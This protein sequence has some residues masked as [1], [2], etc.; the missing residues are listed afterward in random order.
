MLQVV[1]GRPL[2][3]LPKWYITLMEKIKVTMESMATM[4]HYGI[5][6]AVL[7]SPIEGPG[8]A[9]DCCCN[10]CFNML[11]RLRVG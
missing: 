8:F 2:V 1:S 6:E 11:G 7:W 5:Y 9:D 4:G 10:R 3:A